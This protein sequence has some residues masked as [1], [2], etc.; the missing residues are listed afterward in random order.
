M[1]SMTKLASISALLL[2][3]ACAA[4]AAHHEPARPAAA[5]GVAFQAPISHRVPSVDR[6]AYAIRMQLNGLATAELDLCVAPA[7]NVVAVTLAKSSSM[8]E[9]DAALL[10]DARRWQFATL[11]GPSSVQHCRRQL[12]EYRAH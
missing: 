1:T 3:G 8:T 4:G 11:P 5:A 7:G 9:F 2:L 10:R 6:I 12:I